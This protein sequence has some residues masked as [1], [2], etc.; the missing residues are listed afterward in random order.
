MKNMETYANFGGY[1]INKNSNNYK[2][3]IRQLNVKFP[4]KR[5]SPEKSMKRKRA[6]G[7]NGRQVQAR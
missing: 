7:N 4:P 6:D 3:F 5:L 1:I 2:N